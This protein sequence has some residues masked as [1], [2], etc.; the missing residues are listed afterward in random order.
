MR[1]VAPAARL[2]MLWHEPDLSN[3][4]AYASEVGAEYVHPYLQLVE[5]HVVTTAKEHGLGVLTWT[6]NDVDVMRELIECGVD[7]IVRR[8]SGAIR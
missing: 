6:V 2:G 5:R 8:F 7:G 3:M 1:A 4:W